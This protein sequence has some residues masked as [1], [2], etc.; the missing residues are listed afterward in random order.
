VLRH[1]AR[2]CSNRVIL[3]VLRAQHRTVKEHG[4]TF[5][6]ARSRAIGRSLRGA[7]KKALS[8]GSIIQ[9]S[10]AEG[11]KPSSLQRLCK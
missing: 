8:K 4:K 1:V 5:S 9:N 7:V 3:A 2:G 11:E 10:T 6:Q